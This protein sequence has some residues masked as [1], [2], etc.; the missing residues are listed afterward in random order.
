M[1]KMITSDREIHI[2]TGH[3]GSGKSH[4]FKFLSS[5]PEY[6]EPGILK[7]NKDTLLVRYFGWRTG[8]PVEDNAD[9]HLAVFNVMTPRERFYATKL[10]WVDTERAILI[11]RVKKV[12]LDV[13]MLTRNGMQ[14]PFMAMV[15]EV[16]RWLDLIEDD[17]AKIKGISAPNPTPKISVRAVLLFCDFTT[18]RRRMAERWPNLSRNE[19]PVPLVETIL[20]FELPKL[21]TFLAIN[22]SNESPSAEDQR[23]REI[24]N[25]F[26]G[27]EP[28]SGL[29]KMRVRE[30]QRCITATKKEVRKFLKK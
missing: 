27:I 28:D 14:R 4:Y 25:F 24:R 2:L 19:L 10:L 1:E 11:N 29:M 22:T 7:L 21:Y 16:D 5:L 6:Q 26:A 8:I 20:R 3:M 13:S 17:Y 9:G 15:K 30:A 12:L 23:R 18:I